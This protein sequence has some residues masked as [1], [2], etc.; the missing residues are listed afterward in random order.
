M[1]ANFSASQP[2]GEP[3]VVTLEDTS[4][5]LD[6]SITQR[7]AYLRKY[8][9]TF[10]V[11]EGTSTEYVQWA[12]ANTTINID[13]LN[14]PN[15]DYALVVVVEWLNV[16]NVIVSSL[17]TL[18]GFT[19]YNEDFDYQLTQL[20]SANPLLIND[21]NFFDNKSQLRTLIDSGNQAIERASDQYG[22]QRC[23]DLATELRTNSQYYFNGNS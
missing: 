16:S 22:A 8:D 4:T 21:N 7:R 14:D 3:S 5:G 15:K 23:Y 2:V 11:P 17:S 18:Y 20:L 6:P 9:G 13:A 10:L 1:P 12:L 19:S